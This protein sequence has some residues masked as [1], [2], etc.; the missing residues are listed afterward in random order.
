[1]LQDSSIRFIDAKTSETLFCIP[2]QLTTHSISDLCLNTLSCTLYILLCNSHVHVWHVSLSNT[3]RLAAVWTNHER[4]HITCLQLVNAGS[5]PTERCVAL[6]LATEGTVADMLIAG[7]ADGD[8]LLLSATDG[9]ILIRFCAHKLMRITHVRVDADRH[10]LL[11]VAAGVMKLW[12]L[13]RNFV[14]L[15]CINLGSP[16]SAVGVLGGQFVLTTASGHVRFFELAEGNEVGQCSSA[17][18]CG[19]VTSVHSSAHLQHAV[20]A[21]VDGTL[22]LWCSNQ[23]LARSILVARPATCACFLN[24]EGDLICGIGNAIMLVQRQLYWHSDSSPSS[25]SQCAVLVDCIVT[26][27]TADRSGIMQCPQFISESTA[28]RLASRKAPCD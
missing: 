10:R 8:V 12:D 26:Y 3:P 27:A 2:P 1:V 21:S 18:H 14:M 9:Q 7:T 25:T 15:K 11:T 20:T 5:I 24:T 17:A 19:P 13:E 22:K 16:V 23:Q 28:R 4:E 6:G